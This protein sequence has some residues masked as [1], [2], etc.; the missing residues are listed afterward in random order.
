MLGRQKT[1]TQCYKLKKLHILLH[2]YIE[3]HILLQ[4]IK[5]TEYLLHSSKKLHILLHCFKEAANIA[6]LI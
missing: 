6:S 1:Y 5:K 2:Y 4:Y 3:L